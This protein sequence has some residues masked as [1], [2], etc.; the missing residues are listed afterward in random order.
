[1]TVRPYPSDLTDAEFD[2]IKV[3][4]P[5]ELSGGPRGGAPRTIDMRRVLD[6]IFYVNRGGIAWRMLPHEFPKWQTCYA[7]FA[8]FRDDRT[9]EKINARLGEQA[10]VAAGREPTPSAA[11]ID[12]QSVKTTEKGAKKRAVGTTRARRSMAESGTSP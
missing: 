8:R 11:I 9:W 10:R 7:Y 6:G 5:A 2:L 1:M 12:S 4:I 3:L